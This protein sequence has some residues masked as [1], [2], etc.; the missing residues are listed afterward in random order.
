MGELMIK[1][2]GNV[3]CIDGL[4]YL[5]LEIICKVGV[6]DV[7]ICI[8]CYGDYVVILLMFKKIGV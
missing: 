5:M 8:V 4:C 7:V 3:C 1:S 2:C 6:N